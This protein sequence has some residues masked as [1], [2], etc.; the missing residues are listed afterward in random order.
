MFS[1]ANFYPYPTKP[2][3]HVGIYEM[4]TESIVYITSN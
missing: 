2:S 4:E 3:Y 1:V